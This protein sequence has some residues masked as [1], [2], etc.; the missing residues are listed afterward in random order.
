MNQATISD[1]T[2]V[3]RITHDEAMRIATVE[4]TKFATLLRS[5]EPDDWT[6]PTDCVLWDVRAL[7]AHVVGSAAGQASPREFVR[8]VRK[9]R[10]L[11]A[12]IGGQFWWDGM[13]ELQVRERADV[14]TQ[15]LVVEWDANS[16]RALRA[17]S[18]LPRPIA[19]LPLL[20][21]PAPV[22]RQPLSYLF[23]V[24]FTRD[25]WMH[26]IDLARAAD[27]TLDVDPDHDGRIVA[28]IVAEWAS[29]HGEPFTLTLGGPAGGQFRAGTGGQYVD[30]DA[31]E[32]C[33]ILAERASGTGVL[34]HTLPL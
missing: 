7:A 32:F 15:D 28:D 30:M 27:K 2:M 24:G 9:G 11:I 22:G 31:I 14:S 17:R 20:K 1:V 12:E 4:N 6:R 3:P 33:R 29:T 16:V 25:V 13:N 26:R 5:F 10:P 8:Q 21:L 18:G 34:R 23:D 19:S